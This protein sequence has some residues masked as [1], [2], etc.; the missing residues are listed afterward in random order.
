MRNLLMIAIAV[1]SQ[2]VIAAGSIY[3]WTDESG[4]L[5]YGDTPPDNI[6][7]EVIDPPKLTV[8]EGFSTRYQTDSVTSSQPASTSAP[9]SNAPAK[10]VVYTEL[11]VIAPKKDQAIRANDGDVSIAL[12]LSPKL[13]P[14]DKI[15]ISL[16]GKEFSRGTSRVANLSNLD[17][18]EHTLIVSVVNRAAR[19]LIS[20]EAVTFNVLRNS[21][22][23]NKPYSPYPDDPNAVKPFN[24]SN[25]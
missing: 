2:A 4:N 25:N 22:L 5:I 15:V 10:K 18:G 20:S 24:Y 23:I 13:R 14:G 19:S 16:D 7:A 12:G 21:A 17:R 11:K 3:S 8:L 1:T 6:S 9:K